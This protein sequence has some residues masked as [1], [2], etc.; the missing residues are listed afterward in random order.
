MDS[1]TQAADE[2]TLA[3]EEGTLSPV[4]VIVTVLIALLFVVAVLYRVGIAVF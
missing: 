2:H 3:V 4:V 1:M